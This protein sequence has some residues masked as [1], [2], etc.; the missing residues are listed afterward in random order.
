MMVSPEQHQVIERLLCASLILPGDVV[1]AGCNAGSTSRLLAHWLISTSR[2]L[3][4]F[5]SFEGLPP[6]SGFGGLMTAT[7]SS[8]ESAICEQCGTESV[9]PHVKI[10]EGWF[11]STMPQKLPEQ[12]CFAFADCDLYESMIDA[13]KPILPRL[14]GVMVLH[15][16]THERWGSGVRR[17]VSEL[18]LIVT[19]REG[20]AI[21]W[22][23]DQC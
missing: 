11:R 7:R 13:I 20:M 1:E 22:K 16:F 9:P 23:A 4:L 18:G 17:A 8:L 14:T 21:A 10:H 15:D 3:H 2:N 12:I 6:S 5:D 19:E